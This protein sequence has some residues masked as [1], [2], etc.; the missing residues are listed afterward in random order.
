ML[1]TTFVVHKNDKGRHEFK[2]WPHLSNMMESFV[3][4]NAN[5]KMVLVFSCEK[6]EEERNEGRHC[7][8]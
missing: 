8:G 6:E 7:I 3:I 2:P 5:N 1:Q 4:N